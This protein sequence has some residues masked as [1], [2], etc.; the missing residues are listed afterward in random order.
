MKYAPL[1]L[2]SIDFEWAKL[3][4]IALLGIRFM[5]NIRD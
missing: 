3:S 5:L 1:K 2:Q 4:P